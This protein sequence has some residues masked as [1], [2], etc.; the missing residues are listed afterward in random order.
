MSR[1]AFDHSSSR[2][3]DWTRC[4]CEIRAVSQNGK[5]H[6]DIQKQFLSHLVE[7][8][9]KTHLPSRVA[10]AIRDFEKQVSNDVKHLKEEVDYFVIVV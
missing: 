6:S 9:T 3:F 8:D 5:V 2:I 1:Q 7:F 10:A 4:C